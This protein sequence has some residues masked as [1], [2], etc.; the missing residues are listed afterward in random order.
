LAANGRALVLFVVFKADATGLAPKK[1]AD[2][3]PPARNSFVREGLACPKSQIKPIFFG[4]VLR[5]E[6]LGLKR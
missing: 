6:V 3:N 2:Y 4:E 5:A 1:S